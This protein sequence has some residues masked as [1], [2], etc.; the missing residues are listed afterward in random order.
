MH[1]FGILLSQVVGRVIHERRLPLKMIDLHVS[2]STTLIDLKKAIF[3]QFG[4]DNVDVNLP[5][6]HLIYRG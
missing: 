3:R 1:I 5:A 2:P 6:H 4:F